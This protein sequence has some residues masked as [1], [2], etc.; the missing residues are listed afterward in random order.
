MDLNTLF[1]VRGLAT[2][3][4]GGASGIGYAYAEAMADNGAKVAI[5][6]RDA[7]A[8]EAAVGFLSR[9]GA[10]VVGEVAD[11]TNAERLSVAVER[12]VSRFGCI[13]VLFAN[14]G[15]SG[16]PG[17]VD[18]EG[19]RHPDRAVEA[20]PLDLWERVLST[21]VT[22][23][24]KTF[25]AVVPHMKAQGGGR[26]IVTS[27]IS[28]T[29]TELFVGT[30]Y[31][32]SKAALGHFVR[33]VALELAEYNILV[34]AIAPGPVATNIAGGRLRSPEGRAPFDKASP[35]GRIAMPADLQGAAI[36]LASPASSHMTG[37][38]IRIDG[39]ATLGTVRPA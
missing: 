20:I 12:I 21:N 27:S 8:I 5:I 35:Q 11:V 36:F 9:N 31:V 33:Q 17:F 2:V 23:V 39:G 32:T 10:E 22:S 18:T 30:S 38:E 34:N 25:Q 3:V 7:S 28:A 26:I 24:L 29:K 37:A 13:D 1:A 16:G 4:T 6:D 19:S 15:I 14:A